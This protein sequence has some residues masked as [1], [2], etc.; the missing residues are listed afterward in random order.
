M[1]QHGA[2]PKQQNGY[3]LAHHFPKYHL[4]LA[5]GTLLVVAISLLL[6]PDHTVEAKRNSIPLAMDLEPV[7]AASSPPA[8]AEPE[9]PANADEWIDLEVRSGDSLAKLFSRAGLTAQALYELTSS[10]KDAKPL[11]RLYPGQTIRFNVAEGSL[12]ALQIVASRLESVLYQRADDGFTVEHIAKKP[13]VRQRHVNGAIASSLYMAASDSGLPD[14][15]VMELANIFGGVIDF[16][17]DVR[18]GDRFFVMFEEHFVDGEQ[19]GVGP[20]L[21]AHFNNRG[22]SYSAFRYVHE[23]GDIGYYSADGVSMRKAFLRAPLDFSRISSGFNPNRLHPIFKTSRPHRG[24]DYAAP[25]GTPV[26]AAGDGRVVQSGYTAANGNFVVIQHGQEYTTKYLHLNKRAVKNGTRVKQQQVIGWVGST[27][28]ATGPHLHYEFLVNGVHRNPRTILAK[29][30]KA[31]SIG[32][33]EMARFDRQVGG[34]QL[35]L[36]TYTRQTQLASAQ[37]TNNGGF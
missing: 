3:P 35:Q 20:I 37:T 22:H 19:V 16:V 26:F 24:I 29:L 23:N 9:A 11:T 31:K 10:L 28:Y 5:T 18:R 2:T 36:A 32:Q 12:Q 34:L 27:G 4:L 6:W 33:Q 25:T 8:A 14:K 17:Y 15:L 1:A 30:P 21:A 7:F 13:E